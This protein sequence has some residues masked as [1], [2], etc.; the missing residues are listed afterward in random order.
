MSEE[1]EILDLRKKPSR[2]LNLYLV[3]ALALAFFIYWFASGYFFWPLGQ[4][5]L[6][7]GMLLLLFA[8]FIRLHRA[9]EKPLTAYAYFAGRV[10]LIVGV[11]LHIQ[12]FP[13]AQY[14]LWTSFAFFGLGLFGLYFR[15]KN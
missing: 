6:L 11:F 9:N 12:G 4:A 10:I 8:A 2:K 14:L 13:E 7:S 5:A 15:K 1:D 3:Y